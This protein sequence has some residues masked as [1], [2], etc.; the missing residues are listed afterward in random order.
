MSE[1]DRLLL[2]AEDELTEYS[3]DARKIEKLRKKIALSVPYSQQRQIKETLQ[4]ELP[5][6]PISKLISEQR[7]TVALPFWGI[8]GLGLLLGISFMQP[9]DLIAT[10][11]GSAAA[12]AIQKRGWKLEAQKLL[13]RT[14]ED[15]EA[16]INNP[17]KA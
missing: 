13:I 5:T 1:L 7:Q 8:A 6:D 12:I 17:D 11:A 4:A 14:L 10:V 2:M 16:R 9:L 3:T 15:I